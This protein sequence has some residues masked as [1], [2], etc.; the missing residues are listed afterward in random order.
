MFVSLQSLCSCL[1]LSPPRISRLLFASPWVEIAPMRYFQQQLWAPFTLFFCRLQPTLWMCATVSGGREST[2][3][4]RVSHT[5][6]VPAH[7]T[8]C[9]FSC[10]HLLLHTNALFLRT[11]PCAIYCALHPS[12]VLAQS[13]SPPH[14]ARLLRTSACALSLAITPAC[15]RTSTRVRR[16]PP[17]CASQRATAMQRLLTSRVPHAQRSCFEVF[18]LPPPPPLASQAKSR[19]VQ[20]SC[21]LTAAALPESK[22]WACTEI[23]S[24]CCRVQQTSPRGNSGSFDC[25]RRPVG[26]DRLSRALGPPGDQADNRLGSVRKRGLT[27]CRIDAPCAADS[28]PLVRRWQPP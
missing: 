23:A 3:A 27:P 28:L 25:G 11:S 2:G 19:C 26:T 13:P 9:D 12:R 8:L 10:N 4:P 7:F 6:A 5:N 16:S 20:R 1:S 22:K 18:H 24:L 14:Q 21:L 17:W 15:S